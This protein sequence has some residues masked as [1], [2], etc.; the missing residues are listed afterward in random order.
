MPEF[1]SMISHLVMNETE[2]VLLS[3]WTPDDI[4]D[5]NRWTSIADHF[6]GLGVKNVVITL[7]Q[8]G[9]F[10]SNENGSGYV[11]AEKNCTVVDTSGA[12]CVTRRM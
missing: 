1:Y 2:A 8:K 4:E 11:E 5:H 7:G 10:Y 12:G 6:L 3:R 9:A